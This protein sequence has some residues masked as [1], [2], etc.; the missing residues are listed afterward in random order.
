MS[1][2]SRNSAGTHNHLARKVKKNI[3]PREAGDSLH[4][5]GVAEGTPK[6]EPPFGRLHSDSIKG[7][8]PAAYK[9]IFGI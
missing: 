3:T 2:I 8:E 9:S 7:N 1:L 5:K 6:Q 4:A